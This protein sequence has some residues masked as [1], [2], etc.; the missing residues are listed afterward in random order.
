MQ[1]WQCSIYNDTFKSFV[2]LSVNCMFRCCTYSWIYR[3]SFYVWMFVCSMFM[4]YTW[5]WTY[6]NCYVC[7]SV[8][9]KCFTWTWTHWNCIS[10]CLGAVLEHEPTGTVVMSVYQYICI[11][12]CLGAVLEH[13]P[14]GAA[15]VMS[16]YLYVCM[17]RCCTWIWT[18]WNCCYVCISVCLYV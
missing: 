5:T 1:R 2:R 11:S 8:F 17:S 18:C 4:C 3:R 6:R 16:V 14:A 9:L 15:V 7:I 12:V 13:E 10:V